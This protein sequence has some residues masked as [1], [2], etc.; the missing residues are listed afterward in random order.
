M[1]IT[2]AI[3]A[4]PSAPKAEPSAP[5][6]FIPK[7]KRNGLNAYATANG[8]QIQKIFQVKPFQLFRHNATKE[9][10]K[11]PKK[12]ARGLTPAAIA[13]PAEETIDAP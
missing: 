6:I 2:I 10:E 9:T 3:K 1:D 5:I 13:N 12:I 8:R 4:N 7:N 11:R